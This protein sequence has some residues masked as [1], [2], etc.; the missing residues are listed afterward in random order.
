VKPAGAVSFREV[1]PIDSQLEPGGTQRD[2]PGASAAA[3]DTGRM[4]TEVPAPSPLL[5]CV[6]E[7]SVSDAKHA[8]HAAST[9]RTTR[10]GGTKCPRRSH[11]CAPDR[12]VNA[13]HAACDS[14]AATTRT[15]GHQAT[16]RQ[17]PPA[18]HGGQ[19]MQRASEKCLCRSSFYALRHSSSGGSSAPASRTVTCHRSSVARRCAPSCGLEAGCEAEGG[20][21]ESTCSRP[22]RTAEGR[23]HFPAP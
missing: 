20:G 15:R 6:L 16:S 21:V 17:K 19:Y 22:E 23:W 7:S 10:P 5:A 1:G 12:A 4:N 8:S 11:F 9:H 18:L 2:P 14:L 3:N 13:S